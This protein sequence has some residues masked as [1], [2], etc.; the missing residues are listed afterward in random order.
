[1]ISIRSWYKSIFELFFNGHYGVV[2]K[3]RRLQWNTCQKIIFILFCNIDQIKN[4]GIL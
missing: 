2:N 4:S 1:M 3:F